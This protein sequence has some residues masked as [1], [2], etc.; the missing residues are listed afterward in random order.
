M[1]ILH[2]QMYV[3]V[4][5]LDLEKAIGNFFKY[6]LITIAVFIGLAIV[7]KT[8]EFFYYIS[9]ETKMDKHG[10]RKVEILD[11]N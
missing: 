7:L 4:N 3:V 11:A 10:V 6:G 9:V 2:F 5:A 1:D 8:V